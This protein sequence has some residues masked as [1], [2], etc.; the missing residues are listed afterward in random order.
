M[1]RSDVTPEP[2]ALSA[3]QEKKPPGL[4]GQEVDERALPY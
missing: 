4:A 3:A 1:S 2:K